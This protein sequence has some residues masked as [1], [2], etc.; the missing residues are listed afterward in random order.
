[1]VPKI[2][3]AFVIQK[4]ALFVTSMLL[5]M[6]LVSSVMAGN[7]CYIERLI[8]TILFLHRLGSIS[9]RW[10]QKWTCKE[11]HGMAMKNCQLLSWSLCHPASYHNFEELKNILYRNMYNICTILVNVHYNIL[12]QY[13]IFLSTQQHIIIILF[14]NIIN[15]IIKMN[16]KLL[17]S[18]CRSLLTLKLPVNSAR[19]ELDDWEDRKEV[20]Q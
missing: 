10:L 19:E 4:W 17:L 8:F 16:E 2:W 11:F 6:C 20:T 13:V 18:N 3:I 12:S 14:Y 5:L 9:I 1:M 15:D 7:Y